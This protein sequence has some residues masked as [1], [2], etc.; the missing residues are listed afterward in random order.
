MSS[1]ARPTD[2]AHA[3]PVA[4]RS[5]LWSTTCKRAPDVPASV[6]FGSPQ[7]RSSAGPVALRAPSPPRAAVRRACEDHSS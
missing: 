2:L 5:R 7:A 1:E 3:P 6:T 4:A